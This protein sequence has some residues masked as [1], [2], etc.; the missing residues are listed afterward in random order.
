M[1]VFLLLGVTIKAFLRASL[2][3]AGV[4]LH[5]YNMLTLNIVLDTTVLVQD[6]IT[7]N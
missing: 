7:L 5:V 2:L 4:L 1:H 6:K 3:C